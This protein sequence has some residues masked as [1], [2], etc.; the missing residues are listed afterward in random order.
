M[1]LTLCI[2]LGIVIISAKLL[3]NKVDKL[4]NDLREKEDIRGNF[5]GFVTFYTLFLII[6]F[7][8]ITRN[9]SDKK[10]QIKEETKIECQQ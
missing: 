8:L 2:L 6:F 5:F 7:A 4:G 10:Q 1:I 3:L 9:G